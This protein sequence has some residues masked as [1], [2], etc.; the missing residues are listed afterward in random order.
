MSEV[1]PK[2]GGVQTPGTWRV[3]DGTA[4]PFKDATSAWADAAVDVLV[5]VASNY[6]SFITYKDLAEKVQASTGI[7]SRS[8]MR[9]W[10][11]GVLGQVVDRAAAEDL[12]SLTALCV[13]QDQ[14]VVM[15]TAT[16][17]KSLDS[18]SLKTSI[19]MQLRRDWSATSTSALLSQQRAASRLCRRRSL[20]S[21]AERNLN[22]NQ[23]LPCVRPVGFSCQ[24]R[25]SATITEGLTVSGEVDSIV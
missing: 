21:D 13:K 25:V 12:P 17:S 3:S 19:S 24:A 1:S 4:V 18:R 23:L 2:L 14:S 5:D 16:Y 9:N 8:Q 11:G 7:R 22:Q 10:I 20:P 6:H 15:G